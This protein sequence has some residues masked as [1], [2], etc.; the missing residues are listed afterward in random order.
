[1]PKKATP[2]KR[3]APAPSVDEP[4]TYAATAARP[5]PS[6]VAE[7]AP[8]SPTGLMDPAFMLE[9]GA[10]LS[11]AQRVVPSEVLFTVMQRPTTASRAAGLLLA[12]QEHSLAERQR[13]P[14][15]AARARADAQREA[16]VQSGALITS[17]E[18]A[19]LRHV[20]TEANRKAAERGRLLAVKVGGDLR[21][22]RW[23]F[24]SDGSVV[25]GI[26]DVI[27]AAA[28]KGLAGWGLILF[29]DGS[30]AL[31]SRSTRGGALARGSTLSQEWAKTNDAG[32]VLR[33]LAAYGEQGA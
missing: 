10:V 21:Y 7:R 14:F 28:G 30:A 15:A 2:R 11:E 16:L 32:P 27:T 12:Y 29:L 26:A 1:M 8:G 31:P 20:T 18:A 6:G 13:D 24:R 19:N 5:R 9:L 22:P 33:A 3:S 4:L 25:H 17:E 23:Q